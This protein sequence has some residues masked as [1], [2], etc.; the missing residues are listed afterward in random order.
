M[1]NVDVLNDFINKISPANVL[2]V[3]DLTPKGDEKIEDLLKTRISTTY[4]ECPSGFYVTKSFFSNIPSDKTGNIYEK[5]LP[6]K[7]R[8]QGRS[9]SEII[10]FND[11]FLSEVAAST[12]IKT[13]AYF[14]VIFPLII[15][16]DSVVL[17]YLEIKQLPFDFNFF[18]FANSNTVT[19]TPKINGVDLSNLT[20]DGYNSILNKYLEDS[21]F[22]KNAYT[23]KI[24]KV[25]QANFSLTYSDFINFLM[26]QDPKKFTDITSVQTTLGGIKISNLDNQLAITLPASGSL[27]IKNVKESADAPQVSHNK[28]AKFEEK[29]WQNFLGDGYKQKKTNNDKL[30]FANYID[31]SFDCKNLKPFIFSNSAP[32]FHVIEYLPEQIYSS[33]SNSNSKDESTTY[34]NIFEVYKA[35]FVNK[36]IEVSLDKID[37]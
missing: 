10:K 19:T 21:N 32:G 34:I 24:Y 9:D 23:W 37:L 22:A 17:L 8:K 33:F 26:K 28:D 15:A 25:D 7:S 36:I 20:G 16:A 1:K 4:L 12:E 6:E 11:Q 14:F 35:L 29:Y 31:I 18:F 27:Q 30:K 13:D 5:S 2:S 3:E